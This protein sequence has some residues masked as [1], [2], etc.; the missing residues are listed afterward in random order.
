MEQRNNPNN[1]GRHRTASQ[2]KSS[3]VSYRSKQPA[4]KKQVAS[5]NG[6]HRKSSAERPFS[7]QS[8]TSSARS[9]IP[10]QGRS[11]SSIGGTSNRQEKVPFSERLSE[12]QTRSSF[13]N[14]LS[15]ALDGSASDKQ[16]TSNG[17]ASYN[18]QAASQASPSYNRQASSQKSAS[19]TRKTTSA[20]RNGAN[21]SAG[22]ERSGGN[23]NIPTANYR[24]APGR[25]FALGCLGC[26]PII[27]LIILLLIFAGYF[28]VRKVARSTFE[29]IDQYSLDYDKITVNE[30]DKN[31]ENYENIA[32]FGVDDQDNKIHDKGSRTDCM[33][34]ASINKT[35]KEVKLLS[36]YRDT[37][38]SIDGKYDKINAAYSYGGPEQAL[39]TINRNLDLNVK[40]FATVN[41]KALADAVDV[42]G[43]IP[44]TVQSEKELENLNDYIHN[45]NN[46]NGGD[47]PKFEKPEEFPFT[48]TF[49]GNQAVAYSRIRYMAGGDHARASHQRLVVEGIM[50]A[51]KK[52]PLKLKTLVN[53]VLPQCKTSL[54]TSDMSRLSMDLLHYELVASEAYPFKSDDERYNGIY[55]GFPLTTYDNV[56]TAHKYLFGT[57]NYEPS[58]ELM[59]ISERVNQVA[60]EIGL[61]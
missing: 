57:D 6:S 7:G 13:S 20:S 17:T 21:R 44:L 53:V 16:Y 31:M 45:M 41:F 50:N 52:N 12:A 23:G 46:I 33:M 55:Y 58:E 60:Q 56:I 1:N 11:A 32:L 48:A 54:S 34:I 40:N 43:G 51:V 28:G 9:Q 22:K 18:R 3:N 4:S 26:L 36:I 19:N 47:S 59:A 37:Y 30:Y 39:N 8:R 49:D 61:N 15:S 24:P 38:V 42:L 29:S 25:R 5:S 14:K 2:K 27:L 10:G 35:T